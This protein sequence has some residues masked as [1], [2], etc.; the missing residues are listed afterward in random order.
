[1][2]QT[3]YY[4]LTTGLMMSLVFLLK[5]L[6]KGRYIGFDLSLFLLTAS[7]G[8]YF[9]FY[10]WDIFSFGWA[11]GVNVPLHMLM[12]TVV[13]WALVVE[14]DNVPAT[15]TG[16]AILDDDEEVGEPLS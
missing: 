7:I 2:F 11:S 6:K 10:G 16:S 15:A 4:Y 14:A 8:S 12:M 3:S 1:M 9:S 13:L 5:P